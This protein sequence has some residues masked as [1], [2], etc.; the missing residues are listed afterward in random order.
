MFQTNRVGS[1]E[2]RKVLNPPF[3]TKRI[4]EPTTTPE[5]AKP[6]I[7]LSDADSGFNISEQEPIEI[8]YI[9]KP[10]PR[11]LAALEELEEEEL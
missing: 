3:K 1:D 4:R 9:P 7:V 6:K 5:E 8:S 11:F 2:K 10:D